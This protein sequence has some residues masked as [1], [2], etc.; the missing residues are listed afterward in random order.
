[1][2]TGE[3]KEIDCPFKHSLDDVKECNMF[4]LGF[5]IYGNHCRYKHTKCPGELA[6]ALSLAL[7]RVRARW[8]GGGGE[9]G[10]HVEAP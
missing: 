10:T 8:G 1:M 7:A 5:C 2:K 3:C 9:E 6:S 4:K